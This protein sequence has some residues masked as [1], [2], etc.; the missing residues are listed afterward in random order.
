MTPDLRERY[1]DLLKKALTDYLHVASEHA[2]AMPLEWLAAKT[3]L[4]AWRNRALAAIARGSGYRLSRS[5]RLGAGERAARRRIG[6]DWPPNADT[7]VGLA[8]LD[9]L[10]AAIET[11]ITEDIPGDL[12]ET[13]VWRG[14]A[15]IFMRAVLLAHGVHDRTIWACDSFAGLPPPDTKRYP[16]D[17]GDRHHA[18]PFLAV[19]VDEVRANFE[20]YG[21]LDDRVRFIEGFFEDTLA[22]LPAERFA[23]LRLDGDMYGSTMVALQALYERLSPGGF[24][25]VRRTRDLDDEIVDIDGLAAYWRKT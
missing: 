19:G 16:Q 21:L 1:L 22:K 5:D 4:K 9:N 15:A 12:V 18:E 13:G 3:T 10:Q 6:S 20:K 23:L 2:N 8:R 14:G 17:A 25:I 24:V 7:M 11:V